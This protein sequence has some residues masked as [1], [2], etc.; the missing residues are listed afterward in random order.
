MWVTAKIDGAPEAKHKYEIYSVDLCSV[1]PEGGKYIRGW[2]KRN[3]EHFFNKKL[4]HIM[5]GGIIGP[6][7][8]KTTRVIY[9]LSRQKFK[10]PYSDL[11]TD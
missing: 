3:E 2:A 1:Q 5:E 9:E 10:D 4:W 8:R 7:S 11:L 6:N